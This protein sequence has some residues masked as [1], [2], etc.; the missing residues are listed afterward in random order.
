MI[1]QNDQLLSVIEGT[2]LPLGERA[3]VI[4]HIVENSVKTR[5]IDASKSFSFQFRQIYINLPPGFWN[6][7]DDYRSFFIVTLP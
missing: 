6:M 1:I 3:G 2:N 4:G 5:E 7:T